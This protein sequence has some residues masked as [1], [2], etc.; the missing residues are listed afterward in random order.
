MVRQILNVKGDLQQA[1]K[2]VCE[3]EKDK[4]KA[5][6]A[7]K[8]RELV[9]HQLQANVEQAG[10]N[11]ISRDNDIARTRAVLEQICQAAFA[12]KTDQ[13]I[14][15]ALAIATVAKVKE[16]VDEAT[17]SA[18][19]YATLKATKEQLAGALETANA[20]RRAMETCLEQNQKQLEALQQQFSEAGVGAQEDVQ[21]LNSKIAA[22]TSQEQRLQQELTNASGR[23][24]QSQT[25][26]DEAQNR[27]RALEANL[28]QE[29]QAVQLISEQQQLSVEQLHS[30]AAK[31]MEEQKRAEAL[32]HTCAQ[33]DITL[34]Q[35]HEQQEALVAQIG[36]LQSEG[37]DAIVRA[38][39]ANQEKDVAQRELDQLRK[40]KGTL[41]SE[42]AT[43]RDE[44]L[45]IE[46]DFAE[47]AEQ[48]RAEI[49][50]YKSMVDKLQVDIEARIKVID[51]N[52]LQNF[53]F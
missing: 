2:K 5:L 24:A 37:R 17:A 11:I 29:K 46:E 19:R 8:A 32:H 14:T 39:V 28:S 42:I 44:R 20:E 30:M 33:K 7:D 35:M 23:V 13:P 26:F 47:Q 53:F 50:G 45:Q 21:V 40:E 15:E 25:S 6:A 43:V 1:T 31:L 52:L 22:L 12:G 9:I 16:L 34:V 41:S 4:S 36:R 38:D 3:L 49:H 18:E 10:A 27:L 48:F 51:A